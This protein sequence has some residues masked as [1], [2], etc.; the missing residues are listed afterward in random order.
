MMEAKVQNAEC[1]GQRILFPKAAVEALMV[2]HA[3]G[4]SGIPSG[5]PVV[6][7]IRMGREWRRKPRK[8]PTRRVRFCGDILRGGGRE[9]GITAD[10]ARGGWG[11]LGATGSACVAF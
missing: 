10:T 4:G 8:G 3:E 7:W 2:R 6:R 5:G 9:A 11:A 1:K